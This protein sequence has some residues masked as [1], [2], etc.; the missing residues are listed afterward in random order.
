MT[1]AALQ[2][3][4][5]ADAGLVALVLGLAAVAWVLTDQRMGS[6][7]MGPGTELGD[8][9]WFAVSWLLMMAAMMLPAA[10]PMVA[11]YRR[12][13]SAGG[14]AAFAAGYLAAWVAAGLAAY[15]AFEAVRSLD[16]GF[17]AWEE[18]GR[19]V[20][21][22]TILGAGI[23]QFTSPKAGC[24]RRCRDR[25]RFLTDHWRPGLPGALRMGVEHG[26]FCIGCCWAL[27]AALFALGV[28]SLTWMA[29]VAA[30]IAAERLLPRHAQATVAIVLVV[31]GTGV[32]L[33]P[34]DVPGLT[35]P[36]SS[37]EMHSYSTKG[38]S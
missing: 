20:A 15:A 22:G 4:G 8:P 27:M 1:A 30:L 38:S 5:R 6:M 32:A 26:G 19:Y 14:S 37:M 36:S 11:A 29:V 9:G 10:T 25:D 33:A 28:M 7:D 24:L 2:R 21:A 23:Y 12:R 34:G 35:L 18:A 3:V 13:G 17:L 16:L 31:M